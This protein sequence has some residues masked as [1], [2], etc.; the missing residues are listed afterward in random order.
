MKI[1]TIEQIREADT[2]TIQHE[3]IASIDL[4]ERAARLVYNKIVNIFDKQAN[5]VLLCGMGNNGG[6][7]LAVARML[8]ENNYQCRVVIVKH[9]H[10]YSQDCAINLGRLQKKYA[11]LIKTI[12]HTEDIPSLNDDVIID[13]ILGSGLSKIVSDNLL[14]SLFKRINQSSAFV[15]SIDIP[16]G[17]FADKPIDL[18]SY[19]V[20]ADFVFSFQFPKL[21]FLFPEYYPFVGEWEI[22]DIN[23]HPSFINAIETPFYLLEAKDIQAFIHPR[24]KF[25]HKGTYGRALL[26][27]GSKCMMGAAVLAAKACLRAGAGIVEVHIPKIGYHILQSFVPEAICSIDNHEEY[28]THIP[29]ETFINI[30]AIAI[31]SGIGKAPETV[32]GLKNI[33]YNTSIPI[34]F[35]ADAINI[36]AE[37][38]TYLEFIPA[39][40]IF[41]PHLKEFERL[42]GKANNSY[43]RL[44]LQRE[45]SNKYQCIVVLKGAHTSV[46][47]PNGNVFFNTTGNPGMATAG[48]GDVLTGIILGLLSQKYTPIE[49]ALIGVY[50]HGRAGDIALEKESN[51]S[52]IA[53][54]IIAHLGKAWKFE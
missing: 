33:I 37:N 32:N 13:A 31:G 52:L 44:Q 8:L 6:D 20:K 12:E 22:G 18:A 3:P 42:V 19:M 10:T 47:L 5:I 15:F 50:L 40:S 17:L 34:V 38:K 28:I 1:P 30:N 2:Y 4:M 54:D 39:N 35:D 51:E 45:F 43:E 16:S 36:M 41:T 21:S 7:G 53:S 25:S 49:A 27:A 9:R 11:H 48:S 14:I 29:F 26:I 23:L 24:G 46:S